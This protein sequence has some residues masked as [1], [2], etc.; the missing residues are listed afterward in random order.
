MNLDLTLYGTEG[1]HLCNDAQALLKQAGLQWC[2]VDIAED[3]ALLECYGIRIPVLLRND[4]GNELSWPFKY[5]DVL[6]FISSEATTP[7]HPP[8]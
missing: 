6:R 7:L 3:D 5:E 1:C 8:R 4:N 2:D